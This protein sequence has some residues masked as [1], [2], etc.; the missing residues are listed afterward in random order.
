[1]RILVGVPTGEVDRAIRGLD[2]YFSESGFGT[3]NGIWVYSVKGAYFAF[4]TIIC[5]AYKNGNLELEVRRP[6]RIGCAHFGSNGDCSDADLLL[7]GI[8]SAVGYSC[9]FKDG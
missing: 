4:A 9:E 2:K 7:F 6:A 3:K 8:P 5:P 1:M